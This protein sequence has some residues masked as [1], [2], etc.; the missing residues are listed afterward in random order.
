MMRVRVVAAV[1]A[2][3]ALLGGCSQVVNG[4]GHSGLSLGPPVGPS[5]PVPAS[6][7][8]PPATGTPTPPTT[9]PHVVYPSARLSFDCIT[10]GMRAFYEG[11]VWPVSEQKTVDPST[12]WVLEEGAGHW[13]SPEGSSLTEIAQNVRQ[14]MISVGGYGA[15]PTVR[16]VT[17]RDTTVDG[18]PAHL[19]QTTFT[20]DRAWAKANDVKVKQ[21]KLWIVAIQVARN[22]VS[23]WYTSLP[24]LVSSLWSKVPATIASIQVG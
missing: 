13:G 14:Q 21:E 17:N 10:S 1:V 18:A 20:I 15:N 6:P 8:G 24:D 23:L 2:C 3:A 12:G 4:T 16:T 19:L 9:C 5:T 7:S 22:D 11:Q